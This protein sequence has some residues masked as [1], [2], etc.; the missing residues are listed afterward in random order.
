MLIDITF[1]YP[2]TRRQQVRACSCTRHGPSVYRRLISFE[3][4]YGDICVFTPTTM[5]EAKS[6]RRTSTSQVSAKVCRNKGRAFQK[7]WMRAESDFTGQTP[8]PLG[9]TAYLQE[10]C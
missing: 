6:G 10:G 9:Q 7:W 4:K 2:H 5:R 8:D 1:E 3:I